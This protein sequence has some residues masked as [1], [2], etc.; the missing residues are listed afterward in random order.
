M[1]CKDT[2]RC[3]QGFIHNVRISKYQIPTLT[4]RSTHFCRNKLDRFLWSHVNHANWLC[5]SL[6]TLEGH[7]T[8]HHISVS[9][10]SKPR[11]I[12]RPL[13]VFV[14]IFT[15]AMPKYKLSYFPLR[16]RAEAIRI[17]F[18]VAGVEFDDILVNLEEWFTKLKHCEYNKSYVA[19]ST[20]M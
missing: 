18:A 10:E 15:R 9:I 13:A 8:S 4:P 19:F 16:G 20:P 2:T 14:R 12:L 7:I 17:T 5:L 11:H 3:S 1:L 6:L